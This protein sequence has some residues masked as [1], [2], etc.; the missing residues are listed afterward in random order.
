M[1]ALLSRHD[2]TR[3]LRHYDVAKNED[4]V[5]RYQEQTNRCYRVLESQLERSGGKTVLGGQHVSAVDLHFEPWVREY[6][7]AGLTLK[8]HPNVQTWLKGMAELKE[9]KEAYKKITGKAPD[10]V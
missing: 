3:Y 5:Q 9:V 4:A 1:K 7:F 6:P 8:D 2:L 10:D